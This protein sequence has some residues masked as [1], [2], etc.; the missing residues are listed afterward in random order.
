MHQ[1]RGYLSQAQPLPMRRMTR[2][3]PSTGACSNTEDPFSGVNYKLFP[4][5]RLCFWIPFPCPLSLSAHRREM[6]V[7]VMGGS[8][9]LSYLPISRVEWLIDHE[10]AT[11]TL[12]SSPATVCTPQWRRSHPHTRATI[13]RGAGHDRLPRKAGVPRPGISHPP[14]EASLLLILRTFLHDI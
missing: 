2:L 3:K 10:R 4:D 11:G 12:R 14:A 8:A 13:S 9:S 5:K 7:C 6:L 1:I